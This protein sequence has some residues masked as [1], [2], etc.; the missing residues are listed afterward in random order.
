MVVSDGLLSGQH[1]P[2]VDSLKGGSLSEPRSY[3]NLPHIPVQTGEVIVKLSFAPGSRAASFKRFGP[4]NYSVVAKSP[5]ELVV[6]TGEELGGILAR[7]SHSIFAEKASV[8]S[9]RAH[10]IRL[11]NEAMN[12]ELTTTN[13]DGAE[14]RQMVSA[15]TD[16]LLRLRSRPARVP[17]RGQWQFTSAAAQEMQRGAAWRAS[18]S[19]N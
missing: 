19:A 9:K 16:S 5:T 6:R 1:R 11:G 7:W 18:G 13:D 4:I 12:I 17:Q 8:P 14:V 3:S 15:W 2:S 10:F